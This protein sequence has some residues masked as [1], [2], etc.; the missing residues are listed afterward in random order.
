VNPVAP[1]FS[2]LARLVLLAAFGPVILFLAAGDTAW[3]MGW[4]FSIFMFAY[5][6]LSRLALLIKNPDLIAERAESMKRDNVEPWDRRLVPL[7]GVLLPTLTVL[8][9]GLDRRFRWSPDVPLWIQAA[10]YV[11]MFLGG[12]FAQWAAMENAFFSAVVRIQEDRG[13]TVVT[14]GPYRYIRHPGYAGGLVFHLSVPVALGSLWALLPVLATS[15]LT[16]LRTFLEDRT[17]LLKL[18][19]YPEYAGRTRWR[20]IPGIW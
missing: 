15:A 1:S 20:L 6:L 5:T 7:I 12:L 4:I 14:T 19:G 9:A 2:L 13:Q 11:P 16:L 3:T 18:K 17:L 8:L 10:A